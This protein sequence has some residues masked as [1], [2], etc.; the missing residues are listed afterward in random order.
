MSEFRSSAA[1]D[2]GA[3]PYNEDAYIDRPDLGLWAVADGV[4]GHRDGNVASGC[5]VAAL[6]AIPAGLDAGEALAAVRQAMDAVHADLRRR[7]AGS[8]VASTVVVLLARDG[9]F[10]CLWAGDS[11]AYLL[12]DGHLT[13]ITRDHSMVQE[14][15]DARVLAADK[16]E[17]HPNVNV[18]TQGCSTL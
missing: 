9:H 8:I 17:R 7:A 5:I 1:T 4:G 13:Q 11:R 12:R 15:V 2:P 3:R 16:A 6:E 10:A 18:I 14:M